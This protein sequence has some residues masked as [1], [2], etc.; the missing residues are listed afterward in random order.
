M[1][2]SRK[3]KGLLNRLIS[4][5]HWYNESKFRGC[6]KF[7]RYKTFN[8]EIVNL[9]STSGVNAFCYDDI[10]RKCANWALESN[11]LK[12]D[13][14]ILRN[15][16]SYLSEN[17]STVILPLCPFSSLSGGYNITE[18]RYYSLL[19]PSSI[20]AFSLLRQQQIKREVNNP[21]CCYP[22]VAIFTDLKSLIKGKRDCHLTES[23]MQ[24][25]AQRWMNNWMKEFSVTDFAY[26]LSM[27]NSDGIEDAAKIIN[28]IVTFCKERN[29]RLIMLIPPVFHTLDEL[30]TPEIRKKVIDS[31]IECVVD[32]SVWFHNYMGDLEFTND[33]SLFQ[34][35][36]LM[37]KKGAK[38]FTRRVLSD[39]GLINENQSE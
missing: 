3:F 30:F 22:A 32:K 14:A 9:G 18:D 37:N 17:V 24:D 16:F 26:P 6:R 35:S 31:L 25:D 10:P 15:Y 7:W 5:G 33:I 39:I 12:G 38:Q 34:N 13:L 11:P 19:Y 20:P 29:I 21:L 8:T 4:Q 1:S 36:F 2:F 28:E 27:V 23:Q